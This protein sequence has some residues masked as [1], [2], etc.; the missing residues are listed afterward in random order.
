MLRKQKRRKTIFEYNV[1]KF[2][3]GR[4]SAVN[5][6]WPNSKPESRGVERCFLCSCCPRAL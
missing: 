6:M 1:K 4:L 3:D 5:V 2:G